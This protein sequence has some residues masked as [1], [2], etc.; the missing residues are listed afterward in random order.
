MS[1]DSSVGTVMGYGLDSR[2]TSPRPTL[3]PNQHC[4][5]WVA[6]SLSLGIKQ[7]EHEAN[8]SSTSDAEVRNGG[9]IPPLP[10]MSS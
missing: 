7:W 9:A 3:G 8:H 1:L 6:G 5:Q 4:I 2:G 10:H